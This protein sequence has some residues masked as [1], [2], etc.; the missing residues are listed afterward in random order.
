[1]KG[2][3]AA[4][5]FLVAGSFIFVALLVTLGSPDTL[6]SFGFGPNPGLE[7]KLF[8]LGVFGGMGI[9]IGV[10]G[11]SL[12]KANRL[13]DWGYF[14]SM[15]VMANPVSQDTHGRTVYAP[16]GRWGS[17]YLVPDDEAADRIRRSWSRFSLPLVITPI[18]LLNLG[19]DWRLMLL[20]VLMSVTYFALRLT[21]GLERLPES[22]KELLTPVSRKE[23]FRRQAQSLGRPLLIAKLIFAVT[24]ALF[25]SMAIIGGD[26][27]SWGWILAAGGGFV[28]LLTARQ[29]WRADTHDTH[30][31]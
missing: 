8:A 24:I 2:I 10:V 31:S 18:V 26:E 16:F 21:R 1:M 30:T 4:I 3:L 7:A 20:A 14:K 23:I 12:V 17:A 22:P 13:S 5:C 9:A 6:R 19:L 25:G 15:A 29:L 11:Y 28:A 27:D